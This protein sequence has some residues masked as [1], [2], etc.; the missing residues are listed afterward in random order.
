MIL[1]HLIINS[2]CIDV[3]CIGKW[4]QVSIDETDNLRA[5]SAKNTETWD[6]YEDDATKKSRNA[7]QITNLVVQG[8]N[9]I[10]YCIQYRDQS[11]Q[12][13]Q[14]ETPKLSNNTKQNLEHIQNKLQINIF[15]KEC[16]IVDKNVFG[17]SDQYSTKSKINPK[18]ELL[19]SYFTYMGPCQAAL[20]D[21]AS[22]S[23]APSTCTIFH[24][25]DMIFVILVVMINFTW[26]ILY[27]FYPHEAS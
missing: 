14:P 17:G 23:K 22:V 25:R 6:P 20:T 8:S 13:V 12:I 5:S 10:S 19:S 18:R 26:P 7:Q 15:A 16:P 21:A 27:I 1:F 2:R 11:H 4:A 3:T 24:F 9:G